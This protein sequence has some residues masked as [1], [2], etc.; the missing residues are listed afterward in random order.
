MTQD[1][2]LNNSKKFRLRDSWLLMGKG[3]YFWIASIVV[4]TFIG[5]LLKP[6]DALSLVIIFNIICF[7]K[8][9]STSG[10]YRC[11]LSGLQ[12]GKYTY[13]SVRNRVWIY[14]IASLL[15]I[16]PF[17]FLVHDTFYSK[18]HSTWIA[19]WL[20]NKEIFVWI[21]YPIILLLQYMFWV[22]DNAY[23]KFKQTLNK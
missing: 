6:T 21:Y 8:T 22:H 18:G 13:K 4:L 20:K 1:N 10:L 15:M 23:T 3:D 17:Y 12:Q 5:V 7:Y 2:H 11:I 9:P 16:I 19:Y 14:R